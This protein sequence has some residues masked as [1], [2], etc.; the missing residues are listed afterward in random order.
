MSWGRHGR[1]VTVK[2]GPHIVGRIPQPTTGRGRIPQQR[3]VKVPA[4]YV[5]L[6]CSSPN[7]AIM[8]RLGPEPWVPTG[9]FGGYEVVSRARQVGMTIPSSVE[10]YQYTGSIMF[11]G[12]RHKQSQEDDI[13]DLMRVAHGDDD[14]DPGI[15]SISGL[16]ELEKNDW[17]IEG[18]DF[19]ADSQ[20][21]NNRSMN[22][23]RQKV[24]LTVREYV[25]PDYLRSASN[26]FKRPKG[27]T[28]VIITKKG[29]TPHKIARRVG[30]TVRD[31]RELNPTR[32]K[33]LAKANQVIPH[34]IRIRVPKKESKAHKDRRSRTRSTK[35]SGATSK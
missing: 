34:G 29:D 13:N 4:G 24:T 28:T 5:F 23:I 6:S 30:C 7:L 8:V 19:D 22:K 31:L 18:L 33:I 9:G 14:N 27:D 32:K 17:V 2:S 25:H 35:H 16:P 21:R 15:I 3:K 12:L 11:D 10:P 26:A 1:P 20:I